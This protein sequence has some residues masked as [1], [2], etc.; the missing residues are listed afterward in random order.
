MD[1]HTEIRVG[2]VRMTS[3]QACAFVEAYTTTGPDPKAKKPSAFPA[4][5]DLQTGTGPAVLNDGDLL[6]PAMLNV[7]ITIRALYGLQQIRPEL[8]QALKNEVLARHLAKASDDDI[9]NAVAPIYRLLD[10]PDK[11]QDIGGTKLSKVVHRK[12]PD[13]LILHDVW[14]NACYVG[15]DARVPVARK[16]SWADYMVEL[17]KAVRDDLI[18]AGDLWKWIREQVPASKEL[19]DVRLLDILAW[20]SKGESP[21]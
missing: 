18:A 5:D 20:S 1:A 10:G 2:R 4:Y 13:F 21:N 9:A 11:P 17:H 6:A 16:R 12:R 15:E 14:V 7:T 8:E 3:G 19:T